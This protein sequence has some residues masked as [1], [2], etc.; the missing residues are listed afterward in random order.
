MY[1]HRCIFCE[2]WPIHKWNVTLSFVRRDSE[3]TYVYPHEMYTIHPLCNHI[4]HGMFQVHRRCQYIAHE[5]YTMYH[6]CNHI[7]EKSTV[8]KRFTYIAHEMYTIHHL[9]NY[10]SEIIQRSRKRGNLHLQQFLRVF[11]ARICCSVLQCDA[12]CCSVLQCLHIQ[13][14]A[15]RSKACI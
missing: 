10:C 3:Y 8:H 2:V 1:I 13:R 7:E 14:Y 11:T 6:L 4:A 5:M 12:V 9:C 15:K